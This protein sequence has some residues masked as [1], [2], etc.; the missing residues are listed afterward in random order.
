MTKTPG[1]SAAHKALSLNIGLNAVDPKAYEGWA[2]ELVACES[3]AKDMTALAKEQG[4]A[5]TTLLTNRATRSAVL[6]G[7]RAA[8]KTLRSG[9]FFFLTYSGHGGQVDDVSGEE[10]DGKDETWCLFDGELI[11]DELYFELCAF[12]QG[13]RVLV[14]S[15]SCH[16][17]TVTR[18]MPVE[19]VPSASGRP[20]LMPPA[21][22]R[23]VYLA[24][25]KQY[26]DLQRQ[27]QAKT[28]SA[29]PDSA[30]AHVHATS[31]PQTQLTAAQC[32]ASVIL[33]SGCRDNQ[34][35]MDGDHNGAF[36]ERLLAV[37]DSGRFDE[38][39]TYTSFHNRIVSRMPASQTPNL[40]TLGDVKQFLKQRPLTVKV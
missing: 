1:P 34:T 6:K 14:L 29:D 35:S 23:R 33:I 17:G 7:I 22:A 26:D 2:G 28:S 36:T 12:A 8:A 20:K 39:G 40:F 30:L 13:V 21:V 27:V 32:A 4:M 38:G 16:S 24:H 9:D 31:K 37:W 25:K 15:D 11:D 19:H 5:P 3:D 10:P 18:D